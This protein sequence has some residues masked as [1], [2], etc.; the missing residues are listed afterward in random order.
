M[1]AMTPGRVV[2]FGEILLRLSA[3]VGEVLLQTPRLA[4]HIGGAEANVAV[5]LARLGLPSAMVSVV[6]DNALGR[7]AR[8]ELRRHGVDVSGVATA[9]GRMG[10]YFLTP[11]A[12]TRPSEVLYD[13]AGSAFAEAAPEAI[14]WGVQL[15]GAE[16]LHLSG[17]TP[18]IGP[19]AAAAAIRAAAAAE[20][21]GVKLSFDGNYR[22]KL[23]AAWAGDGPRLLGEIL[24][25]AAIA[26]A[27]ERDIALVLGRSFEGGSAQDRLMRAA[28]AA[29]AAWPRL[30]RIACTHRVQHAVG[31]H[32]L[33]ACLVT[34]AGVVTADAVPLAGIVDRIGGGDA[35]A[36]GVLY[37]LST[38]MADREALRF[39]LAAS[40]LKHSI[41]G[42]FN[43]SSA[44]D[45]R[46][47]LDGGLDV[48]R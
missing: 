13:R 41:M 45:V 12:V 15:Q 14:D 10:V 30:Q 23:W 46:A 7:T 16:W 28:D 43:L 32:D 6:P 25:R 40:C 5:S 42:D 47:M 4:A 36:A 27:D 34:R 24:S 35:F 2:C 33:S 39:G 20:A 37:G 26:F 22:A 17:V 21:A 31:T 11:G 19:N 3:P 44:A 1:D 8:D 29:F 38:G 18:A 48:R 9:A